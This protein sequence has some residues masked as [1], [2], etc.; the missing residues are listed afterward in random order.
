[1]NHPLHSQGKILV[2]GR[3]FYLKPSVIYPEEV[4]S[5]IDLFTIGIHQL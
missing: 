2:S 3:S 1:M 4:L 5:E